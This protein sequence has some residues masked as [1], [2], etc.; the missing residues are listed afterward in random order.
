MG[1]EAIVIEQS[2]KGE[3]RWKAQSESKCVAQDAFIHVTLTQ[4]IPRGFS[5]KSWWDMSLKKDN[6]DFH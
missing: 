6:E 3:N 2:Y 1:K 5:V 4:K